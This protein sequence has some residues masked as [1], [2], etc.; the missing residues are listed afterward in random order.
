MGLHTIA[1]DDD[2]F[3]L[4]TIKKLARTTPDIHLQQ[5]FNNSI[6]ALVY[7]KKYKPDLVLLDINVPEL[8]GLDLAR[9]IHKCTM[10]VFIT[11]FKEYAIDAFDINALDYL[12]KPVSRERFWEA[13]Q[14]ASVRKKYNQVLYQRFFI[15]R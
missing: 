1:I 2:I 9:Q 13:M 12:L 11:G 6:S 5:T 15:C 3:S 14:K 10:V 4:K 8:N 7:I